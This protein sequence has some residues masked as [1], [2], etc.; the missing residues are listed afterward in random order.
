MEEE[1]TAHISENSPSTPSRS[2]NSRPQYRRRFSGIK[3]SDGVSSS[4]L[5]SGWDLPPPVAS[6][7][8]GKWKPRL[9]Q[10]RTSQQLAT[11][12][13]PDDAS[14]ANCNPI[15]LND[16]RHILVASNV[17]HLYLFGNFNAAEYW[18]PTPS[19]LIAHLSLLG[20]YET[21]VDLMKISI[22]KDTTTGS[23]GANKDNYVDEEEEEEILVLTSE[24]HIYK[25]AVLN[26]DDTKNN[27]QETKFKKIKL[28]SSWKT[29]TT[30]NQSATCMHYLQDTQTLFLGYESGYIEA[31][32]LN[33]NTGHQD[34]L[35]P[36]WTGYF[37]HP[38]RSL[39]TLMKSNNQHK[40]KKD[41]S[42][43]KNAMT[44]QVQEES[45]L[46]DETA[47]ATVGCGGE[48]WV[49]VTAPEEEG[50]IGSI[51]T[52]LNTSAVAS[53][54]DTANDDFLLVVTLQPARM[55]P[56]NEHHGTASMIEVLDLESIVSKQGAERKGGSSNNGEEALCLYQ[57]SQ[58]PEPGMELIDID[59]L[60]SSDFAGKLPKRVR[61]LPS[62]GNDISFPLKDDLVGVALSDGTLAFLSSVSCRD[63]TG[64][65]SKPSSAV[66][67]SPSSWGVA[68][69]WYQLLL[70]YPAIGYGIV[71]YN[72]IE[73]WVCCLRGGTCY[74]VPIPKEGTGAKTLHDE[75][76]SEIFVFS[77]PLDI[78]SDTPTSPP[79][80]VQGFA[81][82]SLSVASA[83]G[84]D[85]FV[86]VLVYALAGGV[87]DIYGCNLIYHETEG[88]IS[89][90]EEEEEDDES[91]SLVAI[92]EMIT[93][94]QCVEMI[95]TLLTAMTE[96]S[97]HW[98]QT[99][100]RCY[101][102]LMMSVEE[103]VTIGQVQ[104]NEF[105]PFK[106]LLLK[107]ASK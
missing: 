10:W 19:S 80:Y 63:N 68:K 7:I 27:R 16:R 82:G 96:D 101:N 37:H 99:L 103:P 66:A 59:T 64:E 87:I 45:S 43:T 48:E 62:H 93:D 102:A 51:P 44:D 95:R 2:S 70:S 41:V 98:S 47:T 42:T 28:K 38:I 35:D 105:E 31:R 94:K 106:R 15:I 58:L 86:P 34:F 79:P 72:G 17:G 92:K 71:N 89:E 56:S 90:E 36:L 78:E 77:Y 67:G 97:Q 83:G 76:S 14:M 61:V 5:S 75:D 81:A 46:Q 22:S 74:L 53:S 18:K 3:S 55:S 54:K 8:D 26:A 24:A 21:I 60:P 57:Y 52:A 104:S 50:V 1:S 9:C 29:T 20:D 69:D 100:D 33:N 32:K 91:S 73:C 13:L 23:N 25:V 40:N 39:S 11:V 30:K 88:S 65:E 85:D 84:N 107:L 49:V 12:Q 4:A 6:P